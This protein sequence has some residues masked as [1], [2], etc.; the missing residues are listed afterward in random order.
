M[1][2]WVVNLD[3][4]DTHEEERV[5]RPVLL[6][7]SDGAACFEVWKYHHLLRRWFVMSYQRIPALEAQ[8][9]IFYTPEDVPSRLRE[10]MVNLSRLQG[11][12]L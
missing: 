3:T 7:P 6:F 10:M 5:Q 1:R 9:V 12:S 11:V 8:G 2:G 4:E